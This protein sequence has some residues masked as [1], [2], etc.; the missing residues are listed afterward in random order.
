M[1]HF[2]IVI[3]G[4]PPVRVADKFWVE[5]ARYDV[6]FTVLD[7]QS[8]IYGD[9]TDRTIDALVEKSKEFGFNLTVERGEAYDDCAS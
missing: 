6:N 1:R 3:D 4:I 5:I 8:F 2:V 7:K 9:A